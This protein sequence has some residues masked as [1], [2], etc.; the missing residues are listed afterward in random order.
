PALLL[1]VIYGTAFALL[2]S[3][4][5]VYLRDVQY[6][7]EVITMLML[8]ASPVVYSWQMVKSLV[9]SPLV[10]EIYTNNPLTLAVLGFQR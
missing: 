9:P 4:V 7:V 8:W 5:N 1:I 6:L 10:L 2:F 3:A